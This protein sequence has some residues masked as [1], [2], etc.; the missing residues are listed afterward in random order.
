[1]KKVS[2]ISI[3]ASAIISLSAC[4]NEEL[5]EGM[6][7]E[8]KY[9]L[10]IASATMKTEVSE[11]P[12]TA[13]APQTRVAE[14]ADGNSS[15]W[16]NGDVFY[17]KLD[18]T[19]QIGTFSITEASTGTATA[20]NTIYWTQ[21]T[22]NAT[23]WYPQETTINLADQRT[24]L[25][26][27]MQATAQDVSCENPIA[28]NFTHQLS[29]VR[30][31]LNGVGASKVNSVSI[32]GYTQCNNTNG[33]VS[34]GTAVGEIN[35]YKVNETVYEANVV[36]SRNILQFKVNDQ[37]WAQLSQ[38][39]TPEAGK[40]HEI[41]VTVNNTAT[42]ISGGST[43]T[44]PGNY[45]VKGS[46]NQGI[47]LNGDNINVTL[48]GV[49]ANI[50]NA[51]KVTSGSPTI[52]VKG[53]SNSFNGN[54]AG[55]LIS[56]NASVTIQGATSNATDSKLTI[57]AGES[58]QPGIGCNDESSCKNITI[59]NITLDVTGGSKE[60]GGAAIG[61]AGYFGSSVNDILIENSIV[62]ATGG[63]GAAAIGFGGILDPMSINSIKII[64][65]QI[66]ACVQYCPGY[67][68]IPTNGY[69]AGI[70]FPFAI[71]NQ[72][73]RLT[74]KQPIIIVSTETDPAKY[75]SSFKAMKDGAVVSAPIHKVGKPYNS[76]SHNFYIWQGA[77]FNGNTLGDG[78]G[79]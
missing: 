23:A 72:G 30:V 37:D 2:I 73:N 29:K 34:N 68:D 55:I 4:S 13:N 75:F 65:S 42:E 78:T 39:V 46:V 62:T 20:Q 41:S 21:R 48:E 64:N 5:V 32:E 11:Q 35:M 74:I 28:L 1:M 70:G 7:P 16:E 36:P 40:V 26:Y 43:I 56:P 14:S 6:L 9:P 61:T 77:T 67:Q 17:V 12:W 60:A 45:I 54:G 49:T 33:T 71:D 10:E 53:T 63:I 76:H 8:G 3:A 22:D 57:K 52:I 51:I 15:V 27:V 25:A 47:V 19:N 69:G 59:K 31:V 58:N 50:G 38:A 18:N 66:T 79:Y 44:K 24:E